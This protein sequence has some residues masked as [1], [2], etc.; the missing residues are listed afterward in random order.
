M[1]VAVVILNYN[2]RKLLQQ[3]LPSVVQFSGDT[4]IIIAD[5]HSTDDSVE[6]IKTTFPSI[7]I[8]AI[9][10]NLGFCGGYNYALP[11]IEAT[12]YVLL[13]SDVEVTPGWIEPMI[14]LFEK[15]ATIGAAQPKICSY[16][17]KNS[18][19]YRPTVVLHRQ[20]LSE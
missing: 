20:F 1:N 10:A 8:I 17:Q 2:G 16:H 19:E 12:Y 7:E 3:F 5:N 15:D 11:K 9:P 18:F 6:F 14:E 4:K 13:N